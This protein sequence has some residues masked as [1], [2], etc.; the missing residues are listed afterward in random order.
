M[1]IS[2]QWEIIQAHVEHLDDVAP[3]FDAYRV[4]YG[5]EGNLPAGR[6]FLFER[7]INHESVIYVAYEGKKAL[8]FAQLYPSFSSL[9]MNTQWILNDLY[10]VE[11]ARKKGV[12]KALIERC[13]TLAADRGD[14]GLVLETA[15][16]NKNAKAL[17]ESLGFK[18][19]TEFDQYF[20]EV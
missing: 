14:K 18:L 8:G 16:T 7:T 3:L 2:T 11:E 4:W 20:L 15:K 19:N 1:V 6:Y 9:S 10:V 12:A 17:Y 5:C 13:R